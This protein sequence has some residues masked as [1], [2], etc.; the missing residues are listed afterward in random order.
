MATGIARE[1]D[2]QLSAAY[3]L[4][5]V[6][7]IGAFSRSRAAK[8]ALGLLPDYIVD[9]VIPRNRGSI[10]QHAR[11]IARFRYLRATAMWLVGDKN[12][13]REES[14]KISGNYNCDEREMYDGIVKN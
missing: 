4:I 7:R 6:E 9:D 1:L 8:I 10:A 13:A 11:L 2:E 3:D 5:K 12:G 14:E